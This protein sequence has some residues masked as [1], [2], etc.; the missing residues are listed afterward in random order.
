MTG[1]RSPAK[2]KFGKFGNPFILNTEQRRHADRQRFEG[3]AH[4]IKGM[5]NDKRPISHIAADL[6]RAELK[7]ETGI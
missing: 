7:R 1:G 2:T 4:V 5:T 3:I 6:S